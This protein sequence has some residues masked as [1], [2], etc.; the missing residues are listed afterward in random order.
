MEYSRSRLRGRNHGL[1]QQVEHAAAT[2]RQHVLLKCRW[3]AT[4]PA[5]HVAPNAT[6]RCTAVDLTV[7]C[8]KVQHTPLTQAHLL[9][10]DA[11]HALAQR[12]YHRY[13]PALLPTS[14]LRALPQR[15]HVPPPHRPI[16]ACP[17]IVRA[18]AA[19]DLPYQSDAC[20]FCLASLP[21]GRTTDTGRDRRSAARPLADLW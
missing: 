7:I 6:L 11:I 13:L 15:A 9:S 12:L 14:S 1:W 2:G 17:P 4:P 18:S 5:W 10:H 19:L 20:G 21:G 3:L 8:T 16:F